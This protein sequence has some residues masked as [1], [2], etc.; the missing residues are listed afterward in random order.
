MLAPHAADIAVII[1]SL[2]TSL[3]F[4]FA[5]PFDDIFLFVKSSCAL[6]SGNTN[7]SLRPKEGRIDRPTDG[8]TDRPSEWILG[9]SLNSYFAFCKIVVKTK[10]D[11]IKQQQ[12]RKVI[13]QCSSEMCIYFKLVKMSTIMLINWTNSAW[14]FVFLW[15]VKMNSKKL[16][17][18]QWYKNIMIINDFSLHQYG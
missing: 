1:S 16:V 4:T 7:K 13:N 9:R 5:E 15:Q 11:T 17:I 3:C 18:Y 10:T 6:V 12:S 8:P 2:I 14:H